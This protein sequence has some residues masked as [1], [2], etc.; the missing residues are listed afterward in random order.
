MNADGINNLL[1]QGFIEG[2]Q[3]FYNL[4]EVTPE[5]ARKLYNDFMNN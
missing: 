2:T 1:E 5:R 3:I 4:P